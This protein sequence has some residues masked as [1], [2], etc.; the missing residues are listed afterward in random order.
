MS[1]VNP[2]ALSKWRKSASRYLNTCTGEEAPYRTSRGCLA[3][4]NAMVA[5]LE[6]E[7]RSSMCYGRFIGVSG[8]IF[9]Q[10]YIVTPSMT[11]DS[12][13]YASQSGAVATGDGI[14]L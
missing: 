8:C 12:P 2:E 14:A 10:E 9:M 6:H 11:F 4:S 13:V 1:N 3:W 7:V 5:A